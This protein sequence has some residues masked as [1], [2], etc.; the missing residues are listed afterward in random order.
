MSNTVLYWELLFRND[1]FDSL[2]AEV[3]NF[4]DQSSIQ[5]KHYKCSHNKKG[6]VL[7]ILLITLKVFKKY[8]M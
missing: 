3:I 1:D 6:Q 8:D 2:Q 7:S 5:I 4:V